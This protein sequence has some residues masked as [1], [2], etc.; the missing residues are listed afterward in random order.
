MAIFRCSWL[1]AFSAPALFAQPADRYPVDWAKLTPE[2][3][4]RFIGL[5][6]IDTSNPPGNE[7]AAAKHLR[8]IHSDD[9]RIAEAAIPKLVEFRWYAVLEVAAAR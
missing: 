9:E 1:L 7:T 5:L 4:E 2:I 6:R 3:L 8:Q